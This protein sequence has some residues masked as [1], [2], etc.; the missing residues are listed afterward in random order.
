MLDS[1]FSVSF[2]SAVTRMSEIKEVSYKSEHDLFAG[3]LDKLEKIFQLHFLKS[4]E[5]HVTTPLVTRVEDVCVLPVYPMKVQLFEELHEKLI[6]VNFL[7]LF[8]R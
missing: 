1:I 4:L 2:R 6:F 8:E 3:T 5:R 7:N